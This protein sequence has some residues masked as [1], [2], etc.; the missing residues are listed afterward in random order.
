MLDTHRDFMDAN[1]QLFAW[2]LLASPDD[3]ARAVP[4]DPSW[5]YSLGRDGLVF[6]EF[7]LAYTRQ[8]LECAT[9]KAD[10]S[11]VSERKS[12][13]WLALPGYPLFLELYTPLLQLA[14]LDSTSKASGCPVVVQETL[15]AAPLPPPAEAEAKAKDARGEGPL[16]PP[17]SEQPPTSA[18]GER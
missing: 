1:P 17:T 11:G 13:P 5:L 12:I 10:A 7:F 2:S 6:T 4:E 14:L 3:S 8:V 9:V 16:P 15:V 18:P